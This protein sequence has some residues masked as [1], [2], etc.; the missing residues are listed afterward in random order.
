MFCVVTEHG[1]PKPNRRVALGCPMQAHGTRDGTERPAHLGKHI[2]QD[3]GSQKL[4][5]PCFFPGSPALSDPLFR[6]H[7]TPGTCGKY[8]GYAPWEVLQL[9]LLRLSALWDY[10]SDDL[11]MG[12]S[13]KPSSRA[14]LADKQKTP[15][16]LF[17]VYYL[18]L[19]KAPN[20]HLESCVP[21]L[22]PISSHHTLCTSDRLSVSYSQDS[23]VSLTSTLP[24]TS[25]S[26]HHSIPR[27]VPPPSRPACNTSASS[28]SLLFF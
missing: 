28:G 8:S 13:P 12:P 5:K 22:P 19:S 2:P 23:K 21:F 15:P 25:T 14:I 10:A 24:L 1:V 27:R 3:P 18:Y 26:H 20:A 6:Y 16:T 7:S 11:G 9:R 4:P 17:L